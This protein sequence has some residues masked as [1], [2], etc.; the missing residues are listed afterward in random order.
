MFSSL[1]LKG[2]KQENVPRPKKTQEALKVLSNIINNDITRKCCSEVSFLSPTRRLF[3]VVLT[4][5]P[6][7]IDSSKVSSFIWWTNRAHQLLQS[8]SIVT[9]CKAHN[10]FVLVSQP[11]RLI[12]WMQWDTASKHE[13]IIIEL[14]RQLVCLIGKLTWLLTAAPFIEFNYS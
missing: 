5:K 9:S 14:L 8:I 2:G 3:F 10:A 11:Q 7:V 6:F 4:M 13:S 12:V 1:P